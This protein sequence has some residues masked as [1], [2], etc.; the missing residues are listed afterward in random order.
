MNSASD[1]RRFFYQT[2]AEGAILL[3]AVAL[4]QLK[5]RRSGR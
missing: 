4:D 5:L 1:S 3:I 2:I